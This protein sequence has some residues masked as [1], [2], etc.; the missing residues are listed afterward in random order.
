LFAGLHGTTLTEREKKYAEALRDK[1]SSSEMLFCLPCDLRDEVHSQLPTYKFVHSLQYN[2]GNCPPKLVDTGD[3][4]ECVDSCGNQCYNRLFYTECYGDSSRKGTKSNCRVGPNCGNR[5]LS[6]RQSVKSKPKREQ[7]KGW[8]LITLEAVE[9]GKLVMEYVGEVIDEKMKEERLKEWADEHPNDPN[10]YIMSLK[11]HWYIDARRVANLSRFINHS[12]DP[13]CSLTQWN[14]NGFIRN[15]IFALRDLKKGEFLSYDYHFD[16][17]HGDRFHCRCGAKNCRG[18]M[19][20]GVTASDD[21][22]KS[23]RE[24]W[25][26]A[27]AAY[28]RDKKFLE[29]FD[30]KESKRCCLVGATVPAAENPDETVANGAQERFRSEVIHRRIFLWRNLRYGADFAARAARLDRRTKAK[31]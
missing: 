10:F 1:G 21:N 5:Q 16:T 28:D 3:M 26:E 29:E 6:Q 8:G 30:E 11:D 31:K 25:E 24:L 4:C 15:G 9:K 18:T 20:G 27:K 17:R 19:K 22:K 7:G 23:N 14:V 13:N 12:C 2:A